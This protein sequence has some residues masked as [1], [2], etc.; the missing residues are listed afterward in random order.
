MLSGRTIDNTDLIEAIDQV[1]LKLSETLTMVDSVQ[2]QSTEQVQLH[3]NR[4]TRSVRTR[5]PT[6]FDIDLVVTATPQGHMVCLR[7]IPTPGLRLSEY[8][9]LTEDCQAFPYGLKNAASEYAYRTPHLFVSPMERDHVTDLYFLD[10]PRPPPGNA[11]NM[12]DIREHN[13]D[14]IH[15]LPEEG[16]SSIGSTRSVHTKAKHLDHDE[17]DL[18]PLPHPSGFSPILRFPP[19]CGDMVLNVNNDEPPV[20][21]DIDEQRRLHEQ[22]NTDHISSTVMHQVGG[23]R[24]DS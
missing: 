20:A 24:T 21:G 16:N 11:V 4:S 19:R 18:D 10:I 8:Q 6:R 9:V 13:E 12:V 2:N 14:T 22:R 1:S 15:K 17:Y 5:R 3:H 7:P 23:V